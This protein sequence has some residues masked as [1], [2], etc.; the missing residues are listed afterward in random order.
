[1]SLRCVLEINFFFK[2]FIIFCAVCSCNA[3]TFKNLL[4]LVQ[5]NSL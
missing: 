5:R 4:R 3:N 2:K 1:L